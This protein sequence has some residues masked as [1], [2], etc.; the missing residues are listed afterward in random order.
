MTNARIPSRCALAVLLSGMALAFP[1]FA[2]LPTIIDAPEGRSVLTGS[3]VI[4][5]VTAAGGAP[6]SYQWRWSGVNIPGATN[7]TLLLPNVQFTTGGVYSVAVTNAF[8][9]VT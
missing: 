9:A 5:S 8:G 3:N 2:Q 1:L 6:L 7:P 4:F